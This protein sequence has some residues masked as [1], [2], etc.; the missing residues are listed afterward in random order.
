MELD[1]VSLRPT[2]ST[3]DLGIG[4]SNFPTPGLSPTTGHCVVRC[5]PPVIN[6]NK[7][8]K[9]LPFGIYPLF[10]DWR[11]IA[12]RLVV[13]SRRRLMISSIESLQELPEVV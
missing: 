13:V 8:K 12:E 11:A 7:L 2:E 9:A 10:C 4:S 3:P 5:F 1:P 6:I